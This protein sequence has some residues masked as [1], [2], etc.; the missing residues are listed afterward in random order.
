[1]KPLIMRFTY[2]LIIEYFRKN[3]EYFMDD[4]DDYLLVLYYLH[5][6]AEKIHIIGML[7]GMKFQ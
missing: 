6:I 2:Q 7:P 5:Q 4:E 3:L 1:M